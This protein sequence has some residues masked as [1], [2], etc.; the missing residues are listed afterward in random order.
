[1]SAHDIGWIRLVAA[2]SVFVMPLA[3]LGYYKTGLVKAMVV[4][5]VRMTVQLLLIGIYLEYLFLW[6]NGF[7]NIIWAMSMIIIAVPAV[8]KRSNLKVKKFFLPVWI[9]MTSGVLGSAGLMLAGVLN[10]DNPFDARYMIPIVGMIVGNSLNASIIAIRGYYSTLNKEWVR[11]RYY[12]ACGASNSEATFGFIQESLRL[13]YSPGIATMAN[14]GLVSLPG[15][16]TGQ[17]L[18]GSDPLIAIKYQIMIMVA[19][20][21]GTIISSFLALTISRWMY[22]VTGELHNA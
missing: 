12:L 2:Y 6:N 19:I 9:S 8:I 4:A 20:H 22:P 16:M 1:M 3:V 14:I 17:I 15:M 13:A 5:I 7:I 21:T 18:G 11:C 10:L